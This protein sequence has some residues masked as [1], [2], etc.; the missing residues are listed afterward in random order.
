M[1]TAA[2]MKFDI[3]ETNTTVGKLVII[4]KKFCKTTQNSLR[5]LNKKNTH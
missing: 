5:I 3:N 2:G 4:Q 1:E